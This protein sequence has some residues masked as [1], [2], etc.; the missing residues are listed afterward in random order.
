MDVRFYASKPSAKAKS[1]AKA[2]ISKST[3]ASS[4]DYKAR[5]SRKS[6]AY[7]RALKQARSENNDE[8]VCRELAREAA[9]WHI[10]IYST[11]YY[12]LVDYICGFGLS[13]AYK[14]MD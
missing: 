13:E 3:A 1:K 6:A 5:L 2:K 12:E 9:S 7:H 14:A 10:Q 4:D 11:Y 8:L